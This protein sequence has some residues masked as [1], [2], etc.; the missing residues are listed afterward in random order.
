METIRRIRAKHK[1]T[2]E[3]LVLYYSSIAEAQKHNS[4]L[5]DY[6]YVGVRR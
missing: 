1:H 5:I 2:G 4:G 6:E 3:I